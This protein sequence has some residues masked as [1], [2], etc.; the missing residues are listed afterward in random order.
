[1]AESKTFYYARVSSVSQNLARQVEAFKADGASERDIICEKKSGRTVADRP[2]YLAMRDH[3]LREGDTLVVMSLDRLGRNKDEIK[4]EL[5]YYKDH[6]IR[7]RILD[8][9]TS[10]IRVDKDQEWIVEMV[11]N[12]LIEV[13][14]SMAE[15][16]R[17]TIRKRQ[18]QGIEI[19]KAEGKFKGSQPK[20]IDEEKFS[21]LYKQYAE[22]EISKA[23]MARQLGVSRP[24][25]D[26]ILERKGLLKKQP[27]KEES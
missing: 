22:R 4:Q 18:K 1:M 19:A 13:L 12:L 11:N 15:Q 9:P 24:R 7:V 20:P 27:K 16:E 21:A 6:K 10:N 14:S 26:R 5:Q 3:M 25:M 17:L 23:E 2:E 8:L